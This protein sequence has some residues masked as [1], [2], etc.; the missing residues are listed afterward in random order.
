MYPKGDCFAII[1][2]CAQPR[3]QPEISESMHAIRHCFDEINNTVVLSEVPIRPLCTNGSKFL[4]IW[5]LAI[6]TSLPLSASH[7]ACLA[8]RSLC[9]CCQRS[10]RVMVKVTIKWGQKVSLCWIRD[11]H[12]ME[13]LLIGLLR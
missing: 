3:T 9:M 5:P 2:P 12:P 8:L 13:V 10:S 4:R 6:W 7:S 11:G 1:P